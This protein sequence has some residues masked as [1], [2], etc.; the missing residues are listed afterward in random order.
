MGLWHLSAAEQDEVWA[1]W[2]R[3]ESL[4]AIA[5]R[6][7]KHFPALRWCV[8]H[9]GGVRVAPPRRAEGQLTAAEREEI[10][11]GLAADLSYRAI[12]QRLGRDHT[13]GFPRGGAQRGPRALSSGARGGGRVAARETPQGGGPRGPAGVARRR[14]GEAGAGLVA[15]ADRGVAH[16]RVPS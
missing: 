14:R 2:R 5:R 11:R 16:A 4:R 7:H 15:A 9:T 6:L 8:V 1:A 10:S 13:T 12:A 3:G